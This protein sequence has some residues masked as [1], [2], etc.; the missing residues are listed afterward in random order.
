[1]SANPVWLVSL[2]EE[3]RTQTSI[4]DRLQRETKKMS[5]YKPR[6]EASEEANPAND[7]LV[8]DFQLLKL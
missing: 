5:L 2:Q 3:I 4:E 7:T 6:R 1:M 8:S